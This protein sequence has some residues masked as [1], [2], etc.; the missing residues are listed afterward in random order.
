[1]VKLNSFF[2]ICLICFLKQAGGQ[3][4]NTVMSNGN[5]SNYF[6][7]LTG[8]TNIGTSGS[9]ELVMGR[10]TAPITNDTRNFIGWKH[11]NIITN[12]LAGTLLLL[13]RS[14]IPNIPIDFAT[15]QGS[16]Q[17]R[18]RIMG[19]GFS[20]RVGIGGETPKGILDV[21]GDPTGLGNE[22]YFTGQSGANQ[23]SNSL[24]LNF[25]G[26]DQSAGFA[27]QAVNVSGHGRK[28]LVFY[29]HDANDYTTY[30]EVVRFMHN[31]NVGVGTSSP[32]SKL[33]VNGNIFSNGK[34][35]IGIPDGGT[36]TKI[37]PYALAVD[38]SAIFTKATV[39]LSSTWP[40]YVFLPEYERPSLDSLEKF[41]KL[42]GHLPEVPTAKDVESNG[43]DL[44]ETQALLLKKIEE[45][46]LIVIAQ[47][48]Q[49][50]RMIE[51]MEEL[52]TEHNV[53]KNR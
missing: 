43:I 24:R 53:L 18:M 45:L 22:V 42:N 5:S 3:T 34:I 10:F 15:G 1:M 36:L 48:K 28:D 11:E 21:S 44:G 8:S 6:L 12:G 14:D 39:K 30:N 9:G 38:G 41:I 50:K 26:I 47:E 35:F 52:K 20:T 27:I 25:V 40:D 49:I 31:G 23:N 7:R 46:T 51:T 32:Q 29:G 16:P 19:N 4:L 2:M 13:G 37:A 17:L 33:D